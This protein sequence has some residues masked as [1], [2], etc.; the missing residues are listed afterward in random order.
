MVLTRSPLLLGLDAGG[1]GTKWSLMRD[2]QAV[3]SG[4]AAP[5]TAALLGHDQGLQSLQAI[6]D[7]LPGK[8]YAVHAGIAGLSTGSD[9]ALLVQQA[10]AQVLGLSSEMVSVESD[11]DLA[12]RAHLSFGAGI[13]LYAGTGSLA[14]HLTTEGQIVRA[15]GYG[16]RIGD[17]GGGY[18]IG[19]AAMRWLTSVLDTGNTPDTALSREM[20]AIT[21]GLDWETLREFTYGSAAAASLAALAPAVGRAADADDAV[22]LRIIEE[23]A[24]CLADLVHRVQERVGHLPVT[25]TGGAFRI[26]RLFPAALGRALPEARVQV[27]D[28]AEAA[29]RFVSTQA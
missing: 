14:Y 28:Y 6:A 18:S 21:G 4:T 5:F 7:A 2:G 24:S 8:P 1:S 12:Y 16:Y 22:A 17:D 10:L 29:A 26:T 20:H 25:A 3:A 13:L 11:L 15:G 27:R 19:R 23:A 9:K